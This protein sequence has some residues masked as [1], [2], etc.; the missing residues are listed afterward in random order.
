MESI[1][2]LLYFL[3]VDRIVLGICSL[4]TMISFIF[5]V[6]VMIRTSRIAKILRYNSIVDVFNKERL[7]YKKT[8]DGHINSIVDDKIQSDKILKRIL[9]D[10]EAYRN[11]FGDILSFREKIELWGFRRLLANTAEKVDFNDVCNR[12]ATLSGRLHRKGDKKNG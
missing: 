1:Y 5:T 4:L 12:L 11:K 10:I 8:F 7:S 2:K 3:G 6:L 9:V